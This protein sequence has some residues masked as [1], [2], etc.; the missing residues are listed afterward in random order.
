[1]S[2]IGAGLDSV[3]EYLLKSSI[4]FGDGQQYKMFQDIYS[5]IQTFLRKG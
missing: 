4:L 1:M 3:Y 2:G 5:K